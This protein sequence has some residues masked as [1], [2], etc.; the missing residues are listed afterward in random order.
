MKLFK[1]L[2][3]VFCCLTAG[4]IAQAQN[5][6]L[7]YL[8]A[9]A[10]SYS[11]TTEVSVS[12]IGTEPI[13]LTYIYALGTYINAQDIIIQDD[14]MYFNSGQLHLEPGETKQVKFPHHDGAIHEATFTVFENCSTDNSRK[15]FSFGL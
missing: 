10:F 8:D 9:Q 4:F 15:V 14:V 5:S 11:D 7:E 2:A 6:K 12:N 1:V 13:C 3:I